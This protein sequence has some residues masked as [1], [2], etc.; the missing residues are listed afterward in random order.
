MQDHYRRIYFEVID[1]LLAAIQKRFQQ[2]GFLMLHKMEMVLIEQNASIELIHD[3]AEF[4]G[5]DLREERLKA[6]LTA[7]HTNDTGQSMNN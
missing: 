4:Y 1:L 5:A 3:V 6:Q 2:K 7:L